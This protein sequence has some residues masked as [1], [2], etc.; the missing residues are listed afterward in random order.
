MQQA[1]SPGIVDNESVVLNRAGIE[2]LPIF[3]LFDEM[4]DPE[5]PPV[6]ASARPQPR[7]SCACAEGAQETRR[8][9]I[10]PWGR[11]VEKHG[12]SPVEVP[13]KENGCVPRTSRPPSGRTAMVFSAASDQGFLR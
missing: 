6:L 1:H 4:I 2:Q 8:N 13:Q 12:V 11:A 5:E 9:A 7:P 3:E 10:P